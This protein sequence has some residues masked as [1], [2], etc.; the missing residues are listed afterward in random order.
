MFAVRLALD[1]KNSHP[2]REKVGAG[3]TA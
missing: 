2:T 1:G 3:G